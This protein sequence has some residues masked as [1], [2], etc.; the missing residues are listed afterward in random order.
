MS[1][2]RLISLAFERFLRTVNPR[3]RAKLRRLAE[4]MAASRRLTLDEAKQK[5]MPRKREGP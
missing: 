1:D 2:R 5:L 4:D 3:H